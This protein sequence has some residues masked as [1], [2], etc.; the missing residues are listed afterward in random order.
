[1]K[2]ARIVT[3]LALPRRS[4]SPR[5]ATARPAIANGVSTAPAPAS[6]W[7]RRPAGP[8]R[9][10][11]LSQHPLLARSSEREPDLAGRRRGGH[12]PGRRRAGRAEPRRPRRAGDRNHRRCPRTAGRGHRRCARPPAQPGASPALPGPR[13]RGDPR[14]AAGHRAHLDHHASRSRRGQRRAR[15]GDRPGSSSRPRSAPTTNTT[16]PTAGCR[17]AREP[18][19]RPR[20]QL[21]S[22]APRRG[23]GARRG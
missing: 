20:R 16:T 9:S 5:A 7:R 11:R 14:L 19:C 10:H 3:A 17:R 2:A 1:M 15:L 18:A 13:R 22:L 12:R 21:V 4:R 23:R 6:A 8:C